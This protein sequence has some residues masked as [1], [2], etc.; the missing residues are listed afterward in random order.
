[1]FFAIL[2]EIVTWGGLIGTIIA[3]AFAVRGSLMLTPV[4]LKKARA[5]W[6]HSFSSKS[7]AKGAA[8]VSKDVFIFVNKPFNKDD[9]YLH[10]KLQRAFDITFAL[11]ALLGLWPFF[12]ITALLM[13]LD[14]PGPVLFSQRRVGKDGRE[15]L[16]FKFRTIYM[17]VEQGLVA[18][19]GENKQGG[20]AFKMH[21]YVRVTRVGRLIRRLL[22]D[23]LPQFLNVLR[24]DMSLVGPRAAFPDEVPLY[25]PVERLRLLVMPGLTGLCQVS[26]RAS[27][28]FEES[29]KLDIY[30]VEHRSIGL[31]FRI[32]LTT[33]LSALGARS[34]NGYVMT[35]QSS[36]NVTPESSSDEAINAK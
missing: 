3:V 12:A 35:T 27:L 11:A 25:S 4:S 28:S 15:F 1:M 33:M 32:L 22:L 20:A 23:G 34:L 14:S 13:R 2:A 30:Y 18:T 9:L 7:E 19:L 17:D 24:G 10:Q 36:K 21:R 6:L 31:Y 26:G 16:V 8:S 5:E 29:I